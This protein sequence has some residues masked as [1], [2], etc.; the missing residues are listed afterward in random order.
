MR[1]TKRSLSLS[2]VGLFGTTG[3]GLADDA[4]EPAAGKGSSNK[5]IAVDGGAA[6]PVGTWGDGAGFGVGV[7][8]RFEMPLVPKL[9]LTARAGL[10]HHLGKDAPGALGGMAST[11]VNE[12]PLLGGVRYAFD[13]KPSAEIYGAAELGIVYYSVSTEAN[14]M[15]SSGSDTNLGMTLGAGYRAGKLDLRGGLLFPDLGHV[16]DAIG[17][18]VTVGYDVAAL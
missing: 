5:I 11:S 10:I 13:H 8:G 4:A 14:G 7:L 15:S 16:G 1:I 2:L 6:L 9:T 12:V 17:V 18:M 3:I